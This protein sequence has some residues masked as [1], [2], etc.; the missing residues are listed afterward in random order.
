MSGKVHS[1]DFAMVEALLG[2]T[3]LFES[4]DSVGMDSSYS[5]LNPKFNGANP[6]DAF[7]EVCYEKGF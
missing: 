3:S 1:E 7:S 5:S 6:D 4:M 2:N